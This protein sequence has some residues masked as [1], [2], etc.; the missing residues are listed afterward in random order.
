MAVGS[1]KTR[2]LPIALVLFMTAVMARGSDAVGKHDKISTDLR[3]AHAHGM[4][5]VIV[6]FKHTPDAAHAAKIANHRGVLKSDLSLINAFHVSLPARELERLAKDPEVAYISPDRKVATMS[7][8]IS[9]DIP[10][11]AV[12]APYAWGIGLTGQGIGVAVIDSG[13]QDANDLQNA[14]GKNRIIFKQSYITGTTGTVD[15]YGHGVHVAGLIGG[16]GKSSN[17]SYEGVAPAVNILNFRVLDDTGVGQDSYVIKAIQA[18][19]SLKSTYNIRVMNLSLGRPVYESYTLDPVCQAVE[20]AWKAGI[21]VLVAAGNDGRD[22][23]A[24]T[25]GYGTITVP[26]NDPYVITVGAMKEMGT[27]SRAD[28]LIASYSS[29]GPTAID[30][31]VKPD[32]VAP[33]N[34]VISLAGKS[35]TQLEHSFPQNQINSAY[36][37]LSGT[38]MA[39]AVVS[40]AVADLLQSNPALTPDQVKAILMMSASKTFPAYSSTTDT[41]TGITYISQ[42]D[43]FTIG[44]GYLDLQAALQSAL[45]P[46]PAG[47]TMISP[48]ATFDAR[49]GSVYFVANGSALWGSNAMWGNNAMWGTNAMWGSSVFVGSQSAV[50]G[51]AA[52]WGSNA[53]WGSSTDTAFSNLWGSSALTSSSATDATESLSVAGNGEN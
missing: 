34:R 46:P 2:I 11:P 53:M 47:A 45:V 20:Q 14:S 21:V 43:V 52:L 12:N 48:T 41:A 35:A 15:V 13:T 37:V 3:N 33:G 50:W 18:A 22:N 51:S 49:S 39:A 40:G 10:S 17:G 44:A 1:S 16:N 6:Q 38:S 36:F 5:N 28:D 7:S 25:N 31:I 24:G 32:L 26:G 8:T 30:H 19:I 9:F 4:L 29:K 42:Y 23:S 27:T